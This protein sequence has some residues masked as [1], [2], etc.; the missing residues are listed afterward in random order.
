MIC[1]QLYGLA[2]LQ[3]AAPLR[4]VKPIRPYVPPVVKPLR[5]K[6]GEHA[7]SHTWMYWLST[8][9]PPVQITS[10]SC[11]SHTFQCVVHNEPWGASSSRLHEVVPASM[12]YDPCVHRTQ[13]QALS[14]RTPLLPPPSNT[15]CLPLPAGRHAVAKLNPLKA[16]AGSPAGPAPSAASPCAGAYTPPQVRAEAVS[17]FYDAMGPYIFH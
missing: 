8:T 5:I 6:G 11:L 10:M 1:L 16:R 17:L 14:K 7:Y 12:P 4:K 13:A 3:Q 9:C 15:L 2:A